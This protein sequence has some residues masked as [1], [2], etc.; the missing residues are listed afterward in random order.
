VPRNII[1]LFLMTSCLF[2]SIGAEASDGWLGSP[3]CISAKEMGSKNGEKFTPQNFASTLT[4]GY[5]ED[6][7]QGV[8]PKIDEIN[9]G[10][11]KVA[12][13]YVEIEGRQHGN[14]VLTNNRSA[15]HRFYSYCAKER[16]DS[17]K[18]CFKKILSE[19]VKLIN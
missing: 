8:V 12:M 1:F 6:G 7:A 2:I 4:K 3:A 5:R 11:G 19:P 16:I 13:I 10:H 18:K 9:I 15:C 14:V 17:A